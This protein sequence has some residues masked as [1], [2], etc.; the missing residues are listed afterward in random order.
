MNSICISP[1]LIPFLSIRL[2]YLTFYLKPLQ[3]Y[4]R[5]LKLDQNGALSL[6]PA[7][8]LSP[9]SS[10]FIEG[11]QHLLGSQVKILEVF[12]DYSHFLTFHLQSIIKLCGSILKM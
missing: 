5:L 3:V 4:N 8:L 7:T 11:H 12:L 10:F 9:S 2:M 1:A 6:L